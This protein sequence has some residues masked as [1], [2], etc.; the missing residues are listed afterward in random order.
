MYPRTNYEMTEEDLGVILNACKPTPVMLI[1]DYAS[2][3]PQ[4]NAN[5]AWQALGK[6]MGFDFKTVSPIKEKGQRFFSAIPSETDTQKNERL[7]L[8][9]E[10]RRESEI[11]VLELEIA[12]KR[13]KLQALMERTAF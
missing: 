2:H 8:E 9:E 4:Q 3:T 10:T 6:K 13:A 1:G 12:D 5:A 11:R 7:A